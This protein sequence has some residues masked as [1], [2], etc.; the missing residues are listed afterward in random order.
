M[1]VAC[2]EAPPDEPR[3]VTLYVPG[4]TVRPIWTSTALGDPG[5]SEPL[6]VA[7]APRGS[8]VT[9][10]PSGPVSPVPPTARRKST[11]PPRPTVARR[12]T[13]DRLNTGAGG[14]G[15]VVDVAAGGGGGGGVGSVAVVANRLVSA[16]HA[17]LVLPSAR[18]RPKLPSRSPTVPLDRSQE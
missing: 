11:R 14:F 17:G 8:P 2:L 18:R 6:T 12:G 9:P 3:N 1:A 15:G 7:F 4:R 5:P 16:V 10:T 13:A